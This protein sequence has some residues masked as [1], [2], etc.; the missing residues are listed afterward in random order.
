MTSRTKITAYVNGGLLQRHG[1]GATMV[2]DGGVLSRV[3]EDEIFLFDEDFN[4]QQQQQQQVPFRKSCSPAALVNVMHDLEYMNLED[5]K[6]QNED[7]VDD[8]E[9]SKTGEYTY[10]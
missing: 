2:V 1:S 5:R 6:Q 7:E 9:T 10:K 4:K 3:D 8:D